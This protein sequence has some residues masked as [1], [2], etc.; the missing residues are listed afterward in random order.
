M[1]SHSPNER[2]CDDEAVRRTRVYVDI[3]TNAMQEAG[4][5][6]MPIRAGVVPESHVLGDLYALCRGEVEGRRSAAD[7]TLFKSVGNAHADL[8]AARMVAQAQ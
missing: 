5:V 3:V 2:E 7:I 6:L 4:D 8:V 1:G